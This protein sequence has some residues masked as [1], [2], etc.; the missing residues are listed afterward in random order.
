MKFKC[1]RIRINRNNCR[2]VY[3]INGKFDFVHFV[4]RYLNAIVVN[5]VIC[6]KEHNI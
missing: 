5:E 1:M 6:S 3:I 4:Y 2:F